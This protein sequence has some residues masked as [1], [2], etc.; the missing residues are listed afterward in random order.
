MSYTQQKIQVKYRNKTQILYIS[1]KLLAK[2]IEHIKI[3]KKTKFCDDMTDVL[4]S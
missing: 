2:S 1:E 4:I 3:S